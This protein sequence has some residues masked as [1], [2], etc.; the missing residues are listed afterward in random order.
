VPLRRKGSGRNARN[1][2]FEGRHRQVRW[3]KWTTERSRRRVRTRVVLWKGSRKT[4]AFAFQ[5]SSDERAYHVYQHA[6]R[7]R[8]LYRHRFGIET[9]YRQKNQARAKSMSTDPVYRLL[10]EGVAYPLR[11]VWV[12][13]TEALARRGGQRRDGWVGALTVALLPDWL[14]DSLKEEHPGTRAIPMNT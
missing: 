7:Q 14:L 4:M 3:V 6:E 5:G 2:C 13:L 8:Q 11:Q 10:L 9:S 1:R 12:V